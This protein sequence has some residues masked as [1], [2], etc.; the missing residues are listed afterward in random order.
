[1]SVRRRISNKA[2][3]IDAIVEKFGT[4][5]EFSRQTGLNYQLILD[6]LVGSGNY[7]PELVETLREQ[8]IK[9]EVTA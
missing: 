8:G 9:V 4:L 1:M 3:V 5:E 2:S 6:G 7:D